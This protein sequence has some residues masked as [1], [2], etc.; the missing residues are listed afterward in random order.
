MY[1]TERTLTKHF[2][3][4]AVNLGD[5]ATNLSEYDPSQDL[6]FPSELQLNKSLSEETAYFEG[7]KL[8]WI[9]PT[10]LPELRKTTSSFPNATLIS[11]NT[12]LGR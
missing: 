3:F 6:I 4:Q 2:V 5:M 12:A 8:L 10:S 1:Q 9:K 11:G 7:E